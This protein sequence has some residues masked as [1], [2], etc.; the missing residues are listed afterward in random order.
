VVD[1]DAPLGR[2][3][4]QGITMHR[5]MEFVAPLTRGNSKA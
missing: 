5:V 4:R 2:D 1:A 3:Q